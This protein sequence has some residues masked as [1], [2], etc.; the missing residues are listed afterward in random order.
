MNPKL[1]TFLVGAAEALGVGFGVG[2][3]S[4][5][6]TPGDVILTKAGLIA[7]ALVGVKVAVIYLGGY[8]RQNVAFRKVW[9]EEQRA[10]NANGK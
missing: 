4:V 8:L 6:M 7:V 5:W 3:Y 10:A 9:T 1:K 2:V